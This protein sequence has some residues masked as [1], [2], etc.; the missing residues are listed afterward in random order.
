MIILMCH[1]SF[2]L[3]QQ[4]GCRTGKLLLSPRIRKFKLSKGGDGAPPSRGKREW[5]VAG[6]CSGSAL[7]EGGALSPPSG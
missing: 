6:D 7:L 3:F 2:Y 5:G 4:M 1:L